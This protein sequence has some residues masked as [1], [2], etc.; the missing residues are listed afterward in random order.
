MN[1]MQDSGVYSAPEQMRLQQPQHQQDMIPLLLRCSFCDHYFE[2]KGGRQVQ[3]AGKDY[4][5]QQVGNAF[6]VHDFDDSGC[7]QNC[8][9]VSSC[10]NEM[11]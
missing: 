11:K 6:E 2:Q 9:G 10:I 7:Y 5:Q 4:L 8:L 1:I 3:A